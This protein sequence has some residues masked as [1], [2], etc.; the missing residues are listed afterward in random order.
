MSIAASDTNLDWMND[1]TPPEKLTPN[2]LA[3]KLTEAQP[4]LFARVCL[5]LGGAHDAWDVLQNA[6]K[7]ILE[8]ASEVHSPEGFSRWAY[9][10]VRFEVMAFQKRNSRQRQ[11][12]DPS[13]LEKIAHCAESQRAAAQDQLA[14]LVECM[15]RLPERQRQCVAL[16]YD[17]SMSLREIAVKFNRSENGMAALLHRARQSLANCIERTLARRGER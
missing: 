8:K 6:N 11:L 4:A 2:W 16:R 14:A 3:A 17:E 1:S 12:S 10:V 13:V 7:V 9:T 5:M 15:K